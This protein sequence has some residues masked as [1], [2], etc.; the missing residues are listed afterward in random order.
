[1]DHV[2]DPASGCVPMPSTSTSA[3]IDRLLHCSPER[4]V[5][6]RADA[7]RAGLVVSKMFIT[8]SLT[9]AEREFA[10]GALAAG[11]GVV[12]FLEVGTD[13]ATGRPFVLTRHEAG[14]DLDR[15]VA[16]R[17]ALPAAMA[18]ELLAGVATT[19]ARLHALRIPQ[20]PAG[21][22]HGDIKPKNLLR[23]P[24]ATLLLDFEH[25]QPIAVASTAG[26]AG[27]PGTSAFAA[28]EALRHAAAHGAQDVFSLGATLGW[29][30]DGGASRQLPQ[31]AAVTRLLA[32]CLAEDPHSRPSAA[33]VA[34]RLRTLATQLAN[35]P[36]EATLADWTSAQFAQAPPTANATDAR[37]RSWPR[38]RRLAR[39]LQP[40]TALPTDP[41]A[42]L[43]RARANAKVLW[44]FPRHQPA[45][46]VRAEITAL[47]GRLV[48]GAAQQVAA[49]SKLEAFAAGA[50]WLD[51]VRRLFAE[52][53]QWPGGGAIPIETAGNPIGLLHRDPV[54]FLHH[55]RQ[56]LA[57]ETEEHAEGIARID[58]AER[59]LA[60]VAADAAIEQL[61]Q[62]YG[63]ATPTVASRRDQLHRLTFYL[64][65]IAR[66]ETNVE[67]LLPLWDRVALQPLRAFVAAAIAATNRQGREVGGT[68][69]LRNLQ[70]TL[71]GLTDEL[72][73]LDS[74]APALD[75]LTQALSH[76]T[77]QAWDLLHDAQQRLR[78]VPVPV[79][80]LQLTLGRL[81]T[82]RTL[83]AFVDRPQ[84]PRSQLLD[85]IES[86]R[87]ALE[88]ARANRDR[89]TQSAEH[90]M[91]RGHWTT[92][93][94][95]M[96]RAVAGLQQNDEQDREQAERLQEKLNEARK[97]KQEI[98]TTLRRNLERAALYATLQD[99]ASATFAAR[100]Q[101]LEERRDGLLFLAMH[102]PADRA[103]LYRRDLRD[104]ET[105]MALERAGLAEQQ[106][107]ATTDIGTRLQ[108]ARTTLEHL[109]Q[110]M[111]AGDPALAQPARFLRL[112]EHWRTLTA[113]C[114]AAIDS[115]LHEQAMRLRQRRRVLA[116]AVV[117]VLATS[118]AVVFAVRPWLL[119]QPAMAA[120][121]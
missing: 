17:G 47:T 81:D 49:T 50:D 78:A 117:A 35:D 38:Q 70:L 104:V 57:A 23:T 92:G 79:R 60:L 112:V 61:A 52:V 54:A 27:T 28:P 43:G 95:D 99:D 66:A 37:V 25:A 21:L 32:D 93:L 7:G 8:G 56:Q 75:A 30:L 97:R 65:R 33:T 100:V 36:A 34:T 31:H 16:E 90:S 15:L 91:A 84:R 3:A 6:A 101:V 9:D 106:L 68:V 83:E 59:R 62:R 73:H 105:Q 111:S 41:A 55:L 121:K 102:M 94:F 45:L 63:G 5:W 86:L 113:Q 116:I 26:Q 71:G 88:Q 29:L 110:S 22:C 10:L 76:V 11:D 72:P 51:A 69:G 89:L 64:D 20:L 44:H 96:E 58:A 109:A 14:V 107:D 48:A 118:A 115:R 2:V 42:L 24:H 80:P 18:C 4:T 53:R 19:L 114:Q 98:E 119:G 39:V 82:F 108:L 12:R 40:A 77:D 87:L 74:A 13:A 85:G 1:M 46:A 103:E 120:G 67:R